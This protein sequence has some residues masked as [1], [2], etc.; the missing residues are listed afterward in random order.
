MMRRLYMLRGAPN[1]QLCVVYYQISP[2][3]YCSNLLQIVQIQFDVSSQWFHFISCKAGSKQKGNFKKPCLKVKT[4][5]VIFVRFSLIPLKLTICKIKYQ[6]HIK[7]EWIEKEKYLSLFSFAI[8]VKSR[9]LKMGSR[10][11]IIQQNIAH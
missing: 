2:H 4:L 3:F 9:N 6:N 11:V 5:P 8:N 7:K 1:R 10:C